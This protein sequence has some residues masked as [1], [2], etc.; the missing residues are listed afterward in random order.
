MTMQLRGLRTGQFYVEDVAAARDWYTELLGIE[1]Y[2]DEPFYVGI[3]IGGYEFG[4]MPGESGRGAVSLWATEDPAG[5]MARALQKG[6]TTGQD[7]MDTGDGI[8]VATFIDP[9][10]NEFGLI[11]NP[12]FAPQ[13][14]HAAAADISERSISYSLDLP[15]GC[16]S[17]WELWASSEGLARWWAS[18]SSIDLRPGG[19]Y[20]IHFM[21]ENAPGDRGGD[22]CR[23]LSFLPGR[24]LS[25]TWN[26]PPTLATRP[27]HTW[28]VLLFAP[29]AEGCR[30][31]LSH[32]GWPRS[33]L[34]D[35]GSDWEATFEYFTE[36]WRSVTDL[37]VD[38]AS[39]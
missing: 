22:W 1:P 14:T 28:V 15:I 23:V 18:N 8:V 13:L 20:E 10:G 34:D 17:A 5:F 30:F 2:F 31:S 11:R 19:A 12:N 32:L 27:L 26:A 39:K 25:F 29:S 16:E 36:A 4:L 6:A 33:G 37:F 9:F 3:D 35:P 7:V 24:M 38:Y 21:P